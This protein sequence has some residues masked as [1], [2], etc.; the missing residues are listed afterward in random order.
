M[1]VEKPREQE[2]APRLPAG[3]SAASAASGGKGGGAHIEHGEHAQ[4]L[5]AVRPAVPP[6]PDDAAGFAAVLRRGD[7]RYLWLAQVF[8]QLGDKFFAFTLLIVVYDL[9]HSASL[10]SL[11]MIAYTFPSVFLSA[12]AGVYADRHDKRTLMLATNLIRAGLLLLVPISQLLPFLRHAAWPL[13]IITFLFSS[14]GQV[15]APAE[16]AS[17]PSLVSR[18]QISAATSLFMTTV[19]LTLV[20]GVPLAPLCIRL[21]GNFAPFYVAAG[22]FGLAALAIYSIGKSLRAVERG[23]APESHV[24]AELREGLMILRRSPALRLGLLQLT[25]SLVAVFTVFALGPAY[26][27][28]ELGRSDQDT[29]IVLIP[30]TLGLIS[31][32]AVLG[33]RAINPSRAAL[34]VT[35]LL[36]AGGCLVAIGI[37]PR[38]LGGLGLAGLLLPLVIVFSAVFGCALGAI[39]IPAFTVLQEGTTEESRGRIFGGIFTVINAAIA[40]PLLVAGLAADLLHS[41]AGVIAVLGVILIAIGV[42]CRTLAWPALAVLDQV[43]PFPA[44]IDG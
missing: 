13:L 42:I 11:V 32:A 21:F 2:A 10:P 28:R 33:Q 5:H 35:A 26:M 36:A 40:V 44:E 22:L 17:I 25:V 18:T 19:I 15:F 24:L 8:S 6:K 30:A 37:A 4:P 41:V 16:A 39:L 31:M 23:T 20:L 1:S 14:V 7:F 12:P 43:E 34:M 29:Y 27:D 38:V 9:S 3:K